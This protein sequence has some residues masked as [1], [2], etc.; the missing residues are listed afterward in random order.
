MVDQAD[1]CRAV[2]AGAVVAGPFYPVGIVAGPLDSTGVPQH[3]PGAA[4]VR[5][6]LGVPGLDLVK[7]S[8]SG[9]T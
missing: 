3:P 7:P 1:R 8:L 6:E 9:T 2:V 4:Q 5:L